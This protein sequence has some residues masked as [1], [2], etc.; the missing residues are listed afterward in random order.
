M[1]TEHHKQ[2]VYFCEYLQGIIVFG[3]PIKTITVPL[4]QGGK[5]QKIQHIILYVLLFT[6]VDFL[7]L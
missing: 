4:Q 2:F 6:G 1:N 7:I 5:V 3:I